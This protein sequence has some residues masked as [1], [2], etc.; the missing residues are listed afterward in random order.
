MTDIINNDASVMSSCGALPPLM[1]E[2]D[3]ALATD[4][5][6]SM[7]LLDTEAS[8]LR[9]SAERRSIMTAPR[10]TDLA[11]MLRPQTPSYV[12]D[13]STLD[14][15]HFSHPQDKEI[16]ILN[17]ERFSLDL[18]REQGLHQVILR[19]ARLGP[20]ELSQLLQ[21]GMCAMLRRLDLFGCGLTRPLLQQLE[22]A[23]AGGC[24]LEDLCLGRNKLTEST[25][26]PFLKALCD[27][28]ATESLVKLDLKDNSELVVNTPAMLTTLLKLGRLQFLD[29]SGNRFD[30][31]LEL[32]S[33]RLRNVLRTLTQLRV[34]SLAC[35]ALGDRGAAVVL[36][37]AA[38]HPSLRI[39]DLANCL[40]TSLASEK[41]ILDYIRAG[42]WGGL[43]GGIAD[44]GVLMIQGM[45]WSGGVAPEV[46]PNSKIGT[47][48]SN[49]SGQSEN[50]RKV[51]LTN[52]AR[53][54]NARIVFDGLYEGIDITI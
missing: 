41:N 4:Q 18:S 32:R 54:H 13:R 48:A 8:T 15:G 47:E 27:G 33:K 43:A 11:V 50:N 28:G 9:L 44:G 29:L 39:L 52:F 10:M 12:Y 30:T 34:L 14:M 37:A 19:E 42:K 22:Q 24:R 31:A 46:L 2:Q 20:R 7:P 26:V 17:R 49:K 35:I 45:I 21:G 51:F 1:L 40:I 6:P 38:G 16:P 5:R 23:F 36:T 3:A 25:L 53:E